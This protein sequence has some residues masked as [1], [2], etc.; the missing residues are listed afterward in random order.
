MPEAVKIHP[1]DIYAILRNFCGD[2]WIIVRASMNG[3][4]TMKINGVTYEQTTTVPPTTPEGVRLLEESKC[5]K[6][7]IYS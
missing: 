2:E 7:K 1:F 6:R 4:N 3:G 5:Q